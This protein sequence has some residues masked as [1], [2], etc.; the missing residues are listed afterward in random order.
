M[1]SNMYC[2]PCMYGNH[3]DC[4]RPRIGNV[5]SC[6]HDKDSDIKITKYLD[7]INLTRLDIEEL[8]EN[9]KG[10]IPRPVRQKTPSRRRG[11]VE[12]KKRDFKKLTAYVT[13]AE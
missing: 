10:D 3:K 9:L 6:E 4:P 1:E 12:K 8:H 13:E 11:R 5:C 2:L 7:G